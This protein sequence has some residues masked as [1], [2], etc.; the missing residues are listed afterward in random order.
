[1]II[2]CVS[3]HKDSGKEVDRSAEEWSQVNTQA[4]IDACLWDVSQQASEDYLSDLRGWLLSG[5]DITS[6]E[7]PNGP[8]HIDFWSVEHM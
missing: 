4:C 3:V 8:K 1:M 5:D 7:I 2:R 6:I